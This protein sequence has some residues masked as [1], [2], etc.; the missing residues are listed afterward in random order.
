[1]GTNYYLKG[2]PSCDHC[3]RGGD[4]RGAHIGKS[5]GGW[6]FSLRVSDA[7]AAYAEWGSRR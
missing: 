1:M 4:E 7:D 3:G 2:T 5:S 6:V